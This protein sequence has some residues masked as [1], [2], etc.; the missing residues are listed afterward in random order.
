MIN[1][2]KVSPMGEMLLNYFGE[3]TIVFRYDPINADKQLK[4]IAYLI[5]R[6]GDEED[7]LDNVLYK[8]FK[9][10]KYNDSRFLIL[11]NNE[12]FKTTLFSFK[13]TNLRTEKGNQI[14]NINYYPHKNLQPVHYG[15]CCVISLNNFIKDHIEFL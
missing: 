11:A 4:I 6:F 12:S 3:G 5:S 2:F 15:E 9:Y 7:I 1:I 10:G 13:T 14:I 8:S